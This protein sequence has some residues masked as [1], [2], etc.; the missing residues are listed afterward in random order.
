MENDR[1]VCSCMV[2][3]MSEI[4]ES[5]ETYDLQSVQDIK[6]MTDAGTGCTGCVPELEAIL[7][8]YRSK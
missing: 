8:E 4:I 1:Q 7:E 6:D 2:V 3:F 5:I